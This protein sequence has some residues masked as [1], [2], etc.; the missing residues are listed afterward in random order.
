MLDRA[1]E[2]H[3]CALKLV[4]IVFTKE[5]LSEGGKK[6]K[7][8]DGL[9]MDLVKGKEQCN[10]KVSSTTTDSLLNGPLENPLTLFPVRKKTGTTS[11]FYIHQIR[12][13]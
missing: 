12:T 2:R 9:R 5:E 11:R 3:T 7:G 6:S 8:L 4:N 13:Y 1:I 10:I